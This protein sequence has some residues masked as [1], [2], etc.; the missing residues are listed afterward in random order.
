MC[1]DDEDI[2]Q[3]DLYNGGECSVYFVASIFVV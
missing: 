3:T 1:G 2:R